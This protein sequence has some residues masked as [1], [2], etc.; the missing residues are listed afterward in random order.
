MVRKELLPQGNQGK[1]R[2]KLTQLS[3]LCWHLEGW[4]KFPALVS[5]SKIQLLGGWELDLG[6]A[7]LPG[8]TDGG[9]SQQVPEVDLPLLSLAAMLLTMLTLTDYSQGAA[10]PKCNV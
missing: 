5:E 3:D 1:G 9:K 7:A 10:V 8:I 6:D 2:K 4:L